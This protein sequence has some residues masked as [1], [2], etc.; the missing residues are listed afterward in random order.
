MDIEIGSRVIVEFTGK[1]RMTCHFLGLERD[2]FIILK[3]P[4]VP[5][6]RERMGEGAFLQFRYLRKG[7]IVSFGGEILRY[8][9]TPASIVF[10][11]YPTD[12]SVYNLRSQGRI[13]CRFPTELALAG[14][15]YPGFI[16]D[17][18]RQGCKFMFSGGQATKP[19]DGA[20]VSGFFK[21]MEGDRKY[22]FSGTVASVQTVDDARA[23]GI[24]FE[25]DVELPKGA[26]E[27]LANLD[28]M[29]RAAGS[30]KQG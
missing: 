24:T 12:F 3:V 10:V 7:Q 17:I 28:E 27:L 25:G 11:R 22:E 23:L 21:T 6:I 14:T 26:S 15:S 4:M 1:E 20:S 9:A 29:Q 18:N 30:G 13:E 19:E 16:V 2:E 8:Q 5:G